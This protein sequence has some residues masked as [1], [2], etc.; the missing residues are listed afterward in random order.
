MHSDRWPSPTADF[1]PTEQGLTV[2]F[3]GVAGEQNRPR[4]AILAEWMAEVGGAEQVT[5]AMLSAFPSSDLWTLASRDDQARSPLAGIMLSPTTDRRLLAAISTLA[6]RHGSFRPGEYDVVISSHHLQTHT[7]ATEDVPHLAYVH[8][9]A[10]YA[11]FPEQ[12]D[13]ASG[14][15]GR[16][17]AA[18]IRSNDRRAARVV[19]AY[20][21]NS[22]ATARRLKTVWDVDAEVIYPPV[23]AARLAARPGQ[24][25]EDF[26]LAV[27]RFIPYK[28]LDFA[29]EVAEAVRRPL[30]IAGSGPM[31]D[32]LMRQAKQVHVPVRIID[33]PST[34]QILNLYSRASALLFP[35][36]EDFGI[37]PVEAMACGLPVVAQG[38]GGAAESVVDH[39]SGKLVSGTDLEEWRSAVRAVE[40]IRPE[41]CV[42]VAL[43]FDIAKFRERI[44]AWV[45]RWSSL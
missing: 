26:L 10:R 22:R 28:R 5:E 38:A 37:V 43:Q 15:V 32:E 20:A 42:E 9:P 11:W 27:S 45:A 8:S 2:R 44:V 31:R 33:E 41:R 6:W 16:A 36:V 17:I 18:R 29:I 30:V 39:V 7:A 34:E 25:R 4:I 1:A 13:R 14:L 23:P 21:A 40:E 3:S 12:D 19:R 24:V 35:G